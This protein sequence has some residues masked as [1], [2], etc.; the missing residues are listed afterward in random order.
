M[1]NM[2][3]TKAFNARNSEWKTLTESKRVLQESRGLVKAE[4]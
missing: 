2:R 1:T 4:E 3:K